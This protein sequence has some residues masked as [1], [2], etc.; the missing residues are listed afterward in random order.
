MSSD[1]DP[2]LIKNSL[3]DLI[4]ENKIFPFLY[5][6]IK[7]LKQYL[8]EQKLLF[9]LMGVFGAIGI[10]S[11]R[12]AI[13]ETGSLSHVAEFGFVSSFS[14]VILLSFI[15]LVDLAIIIRRNGGILSYENWGLGLFSIF[16]FPL[17]FVIA[18]L[19]SR[20]REVWAIYQF[21]ASYSFG[22]FLP[23]ATLIGVL[24]ISDK[25]PEDWR[26]SST[27][28]LSVLTAYPVTSIYLYYR[29]RPVVE[30][31]PSIANGLTFNETLSLFLTFGMAS[32]LLMAILLVVL[33][34][35]SFLILLVKWSLKKLRWLKNLV[36]N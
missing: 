17:M 34:I 30:E 7:G 23:V 5:S 28:K 8:N 20:Y 10:Y 11:Y 26:F 33:L 35:L 18:A 22:L 3:E 19:V 27:L 9:T 15:A 2:T 25:I 16:F 36:T 12:V 21:M 24:D 29:L 13:E 1:S 14:L 6:P 31:T 4:L 32:A